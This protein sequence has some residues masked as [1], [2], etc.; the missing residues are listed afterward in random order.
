MVFWLVSRGPRAGQVIGSGLAGAAGSGIGRSASDLRQVVG[1]PAVPG[2]E[3][4]A[5]CASRMVP[6]PSSQGPEATI[7]SYRIRNRLRLPAV[8]RWTTALLS[9]SRIPAVDL[10]FD[11]LT[12]ALVSLR[13]SARQVMSSVWGDS[14][15]KVWT[16][17]KVLSL[18]SLGLLLE[19]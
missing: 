9:R 4:L 1:E 10:P 17:A 8:E 19:G 5:V 15:A 13:M 14:P 3:G 2:P 11:R 7:R 6:D 16:A 18:A 12:H